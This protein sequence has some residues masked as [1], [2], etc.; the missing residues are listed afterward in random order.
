MVLCAFFQAIFGR[1]LYVLDC[2]AIDG[3]FKVRKDE[4]CKVSNNLCEQNIF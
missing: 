1:L 2:N 3:T 4:E